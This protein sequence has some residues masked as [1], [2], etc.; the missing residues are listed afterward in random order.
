MDYQRFDM[1]SEYLNNLTS[2]TLR[3]G[4]IF[5]TVGCSVL[6]VISFLQFLSFHSKTFFQ[7]SLF[8]FIPAI[9]FL[10]LSKTYF[11]KNVTL[12][13][14]FHTITLIGA[15]LMKLSVFITS[16]YYLSTP[17][18]S[19]VAALTGGLA[20]ITFLIYLASAG[21]RKY[22]PYMIIPTIL[23]TCLIVLIKRGLNPIEL[24]FFISPIMVQLVTVVF[25]VQQEKYAYHNF[26][27]RKLFESAKNKLALEIKERKNAEEKFYNY[28]HR[29]ELTKLFNRRVAFSI[30]KK[31]MERTLT[32]GSPL[33]I[34]FI[35][36]DKLK[37]VND[38]LGHSEGDSMLIKV[39]N[40]LKDNVRVT[41]YICRIGGDE[42]LIIFPDC[43]IANVE[44]IINRIREKLNSECNIDFSYGCSEYVQ[45]SNISA[46]ELVKLAD[47][48]M[49]SDKLK[50]KNYSK[51]KKPILNNLQQQSLFE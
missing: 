26:V 10:V 43:H 19:T 34:C 16:Y 44:T 29:D 8:F 17:N 51:K 11:P 13:I 6:A 48:N 38:S 31:Q 46:E 15:F 35:D 50:K 2:V 21:A 14:P 40:Y 25:A 49:Y 39:A 45:S 32:T 30:L 9:V 27:I 5:A 1:E 42:F 24:S 37:Q 3:T 23:T 41:D 22:L 47:S 12:I 20:A 36:V 7:C 4:K 18:Y 28:L 33:T